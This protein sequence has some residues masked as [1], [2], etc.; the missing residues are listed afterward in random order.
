MIMQA[1][2]TVA[3]KNSA[4]IIVAGPDT[5]S[6]EGY[7]VFDVPAGEGYTIKITDA[8]SHCWIWPDIVIDADSNGN[9][10]LSDD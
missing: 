5:T 3:V 10:L 7:F 6:P 2:M 1:G 9:Y 8:E 4:G